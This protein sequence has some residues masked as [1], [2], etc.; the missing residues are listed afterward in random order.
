M[1]AEIKKWGNSLAVRLPKDLV[2]SLHLHDGSPV[3]L[4]VKDGVLLIRPQQRRP[5]RGGMT[6]DHLLEGV[7]PEGIHRDTEW[8][9]PVGS[10][11]W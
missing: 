1:N 10:E 3:E 6:L 9:G 11:V 7:T 5:Q 4:E 2:Q 8:G